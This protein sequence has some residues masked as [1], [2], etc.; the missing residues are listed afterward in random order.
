MPLYD[1]STNLAAQG[2]FAPGV[3]YRADIRKPT[4]PMPNFPEG[5]YQFN[6]DLDSVGRALAQ[7]SRDQASVDETRFKL[8]YAKKEKAEKAAEKQLQIDTSNALAQEISDVTAQLDQGLINPLTASRMQKEIKDRYRAMRILDA[9]Q[10]AA[11]ANAEDGGAS[12]FLEKRREQYGNWELGEKTKRLTDIHNKVPSSNNMSDAEALNLSYNIE[13]AG[14]KAAAAAISAKNNSGTQELATLSNQTLLREGMDAALYQATSTISNAVTTTP[15]MTPTQVLQNA[16]MNTF[17]Y[18]KDELGAS[19]EVAYAAMTSA[20]DKIKPITDIWNN[21]TKEE[22][23]YVKNKLSIMQDTAQ[24]NLWNRFPSQML[25]SKNTNLDFSSYGI[26]YNEGIDGKQGSVV[27]PAPTVQTTA[28]Y[29]Q[30]GSSFVSTQVPTS[31]T[32]ANGVTLPLTEETAYISRHPE[33]YMLSIATGRVPVGQYI[34]RP[35]ALGTVAAAGYNNNI[36]LSGER[37]ASASAQDLRTA[38]ANGKSFYGNINTAAGQNFLKKQGEYDGVSDYNKIFESYNTSEGLDIRANDPEHWNKVFYEHGRPIQD[39]KYLYNFLR[40]APNDGSLQ[41]APVTGKINNIVDAVAADKF[42][43]HVRAINIETSGYE[44]EARASLIRSLVNKDGQGV[45]TGDPKTDLVLSSDSTLTEKAVRGV[46]EGFKWVNKNVVNKY[47]IP[48][49]EKAYNWMKEKA[50][51]VI[52]WAE[53]QGYNVGATYSNWLEENDREDN[54]TSRKD[55]LLQASAKYV[56][57]LEDRLQE[58]R[59]RSEVDA[60]LDTIT[61]ESLSNTDG[62]DFQRGT[63]D[64]RDPSQLPVHIFEDGKWGNL[65]YGTIT[66]DGRTFVVPGFDDKGNVSDNKTEFDKGRYFF[67]IAGDNKRAK[68]MAENIAKRMRQYVIDRDGPAI[69]ALMNPSQ[70]GLSDINPPMSYRPDAREGISSRDVSDSPKISSNDI[71]NLIEQNATDTNQNIENIK[72]VADNLS[73]EDKNFIEEIGKAVKKSLLDEKATAFKAGLTGD[74]EDVDKFFKDYNTFGEKYGFVAQTLWLADKIIPF[75]AGSATQVAT[76][77]AEE[78]GKWVYA[79]LSIPGVH[80][81]NLSERTDR[82]LKDIVRRN[83]TRYEQTYRSGIDTVDMLLDPSQLFERE[84][85]QFESNK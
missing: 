60:M 10:I 85:L 46:E 1:Q 18:F 65:R 38:S 55:F 43:E 16:S 47:A 82:R 41:M 26:Q 56:R 48:T 21:G 78:L 61:P 57:D 3:N 8:E 12:T 53:K 54:W 22:A 73:E 7:M 66:A 70:T 14:I 15:N 24:I 76:G 62:L 36:N 30:Q 52:D 69:E 32:F 23:E 44:P 51:D 50:G 39:S 25:A 6:V 2:R 37:A 58:N 4:Q 63:V 34:G 9:S 20:M 74:K 71:S 11:T 28:Q 75:V 17:R 79:L 5:K 45:P 68:D 40:I 67:S 31:V 84:P 59:A 72:K 35:V 80:F 27:L 77:S 19:D 81:E 83:I 13:Q 33:E 29:A 64:V 42:K 49:E